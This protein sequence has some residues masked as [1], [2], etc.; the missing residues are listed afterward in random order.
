MEKASWGF[1]PNYR[2]LL[3]TVRKRQVDVVLVWSYDRFARS[4]VELILAVDEFRT[5][6][7][8]FISYQQN[9]DTTTPHGRLYFTVAAGFAEFESAQL[10]L[11]GHT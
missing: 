5:L 6:D 4:T 11:G 9:I 3:D 7:V 8:D 10:A 1:L 2:R